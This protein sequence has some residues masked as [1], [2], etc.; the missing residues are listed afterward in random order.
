MDQQSI[1]DHYQ[2]NGWAGVFCLLG[3]LSVILGAFG[4]HGLE[5][6]IS[7]SSLSA[8]QT[9]VLYHFIHVL[10]GLA[11]VVSARKRADQW[12]TISCWCLLLGILFF[13]GSLYLLS[14]SSL[15]GID[16]GFLGPVTPIGGLL[17]IVAWISLAIHYLKKR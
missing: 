14:T 11:A 6:R 3:A 5:D 7:A 13:S 16:F 4:A 12:L 17:F 10:A 8:Y 15:W 1:R 2:L 9:G